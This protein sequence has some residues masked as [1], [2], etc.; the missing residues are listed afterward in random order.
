MNTHA[1]PFDEQV[2]AAELIL[3]VRLLAAVRWRRRDA[4]EHSDVKINCGAI[5][6]METQMEIQMETQMETD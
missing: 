3:W 6:R 5:A 1:D 2:E 4:G